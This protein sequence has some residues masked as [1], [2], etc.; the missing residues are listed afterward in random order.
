MRSVYF[1]IVRLSITAEQTN[2]NTY[3]VVGVLKCD[4]LFLHGAQDCLECVDKVGEDDDAPLPSVT[5]TEATGVKHAH[6]LEN[7]RLA[8]LT[9]ACTLHGQPRL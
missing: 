5:G 8:A 2:S 7:G 4:V 3:I 1:W 6:L 9:G